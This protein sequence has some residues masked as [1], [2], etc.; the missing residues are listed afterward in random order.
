MPLA[1]IDELVGISNGGLYCISPD[2]PCEGASTDFKI[3]RTI[4]FRK[5]LNSYHIC[6]NEGFYIYAVLPLSKKYKMDTKE[7]RAEAVDTTKKIEA[8]AFVLLKKHNKLFSTRR[9][10]SEWFGC[11]KNVVV[12]VF[13]Q[14]NKEF[15]DD[16]VPPIYHWEDDFVDDFRIDGFRVKLQTE[17]PS[18]LPSSIKRKKGERTPKLPKSYSDFKFFSKDSENVPKSTTRWIRHVNAFR[19]KNPSLSYNNALKAASKT[20]KRI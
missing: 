7:E 2:P 6:Y 18:Y 3:G 10:K 4:D 13:T 14:L 19:K 12:A 15:E 9:R 1:K 16:T 5:R 11:L 20:Y 8:R 17:V